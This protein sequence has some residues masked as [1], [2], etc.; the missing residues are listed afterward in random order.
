MDHVLW[1]SGA[2]RFSRAAPRG[3]RCRDEAHEGSSDSQRRPSLGDAPTSTFAVSR[4]T[5]PSMPRSALRPS[6]IVCKSGAVATFALSL[7]PRVLPLDYLPGGR[8]R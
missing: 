2:G 8:K 4:G 3:P 7:M 6:S 5:S 1:A